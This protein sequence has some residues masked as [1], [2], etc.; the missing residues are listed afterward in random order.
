MTQTVTESLT[1]LFL[2]ES[3]HGPTNQCIGLGKV[4]L[5]RGH[6][7]VFAAE[8]SW[9]G[10]LAPLGF[11]EAL[12]DLAP[13]APTPIPTPARRP[14]AS[15]GSTSSTRRRPEFRKPTVEQLASF[16]QPTYQAL[17]DGAMYCRATAQGDHRRAPSRRA[18]RGQ[19][20]RLPRAGDLRRTVR[21]DRVVQPVGGA[22]RRRRRRSSPAT[23]PPTRRSGPR[24]SRSST[25]PTRRRGS[26]STRGCSS[27]ARRRCLAATSSTPPRRPTCTSSLR[28]WT[29]STPGRSARPGTGSTPACARPTPTS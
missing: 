4:L 13:A 11:V 22:R 19:R 12:V 9:E 21:A 23:R 26:G 6:R 7:V 2:P 27:R 10:K 14:P 20:R 25:A 18:G 1:V 3:A 24:S 8:R 17:I 16:V 15:S 28:S 5:D 29:T